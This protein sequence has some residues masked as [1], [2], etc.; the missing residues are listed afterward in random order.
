[1][2]RKP[3]KVSCIVAFSQ[4]SEVQGTNNGIREILS[5]SITDN[6]YQ[7]LFKINQ[8]RVSSFGMSLNDLLQTADAKRM[9]L[10]LPKE[11]TSDQRTVLVPEFPMRGTF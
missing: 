4:L 5:L 6:E 7:A 10:H 9:F 2:I 1:M 3:Q 8:C 11:R